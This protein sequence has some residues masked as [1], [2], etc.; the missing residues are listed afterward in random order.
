M[1]MSDYYD[2]IDPDI[3]PDIDDDYDPDEDDFAEDDDELELI[4]GRHRHEEE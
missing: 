2:Q 3:D 4:E 1:R